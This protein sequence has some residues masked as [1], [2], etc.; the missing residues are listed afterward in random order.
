[1]NRI[2]WI[3]LGVVLPLLADEPMLADARVE[4]GVPIVPDVEMTNRMK[5]LERESAHC[6][7][8][9]F[10]L[11]K[12][13]TGLPNHSCGNGHQTE[14]QQRAFK[15]WLAIAMA[16]PETT[17]EQLDAIWRLLILG[18][19][20]TDGTGLFLIYQ[21]AGLKR[22][23][24]DLKRA[25]KVVQETEDAAHPYKRIAFESARKSLQQH[26]AASER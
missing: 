25:E 17:D 18:S 16:S 15:Y 9:A 6:P 7:A 12:L 8:A 3:I 19:V 1:M 11:A 2:P 24:A 14:L 23:D 13:Q 10:E 21:K 26:V 4:P 20:P 5:L 22:I